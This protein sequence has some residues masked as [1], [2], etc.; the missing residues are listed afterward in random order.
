MDA[1]AEAVRGVGDGFNHAIVTGGDDAEGAG[2]GDA[3][4]VVAGD[5]G[6]DEP[7]R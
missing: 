1:E 3:L 7:R 2:I 6:A 5:L 4:A